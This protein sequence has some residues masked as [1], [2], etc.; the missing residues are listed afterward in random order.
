MRG[1][2]LEKYFS[3]LKLYIMEDNSN[4]SV[5]VVEDDKYMN[6]TLC[7]VLEGE[8]FNV[9]SATTVLD[10]ISKLK[11]TKKSYTLLVVDYNLLSLHGITG[12]DIFKTAKEIY[13]G[14]K[15]IMM[16]AYGSN[17]IKE[18]AFESG[19]NMFIDKPFKITELVEALHLVTH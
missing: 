1:V 14:I 15:S 6:E 5:L 13:P 4:I 16:S 17:K 10:A 11:N 3:G 7:E 2:V 19:I 18:K 8:G 9:N 12:I